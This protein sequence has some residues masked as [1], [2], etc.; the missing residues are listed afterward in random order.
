MSTSATEAFKPMRIRHVAIYV[1]QT[2]ARTF[3]GGA[4]SQDPGFNRTQPI[5]EGRGVASRPFIMGGRD[6]WA[7]FYLFVAG[8]LGGT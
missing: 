4:G 8:Q 1:L 5:M 3:T 2:T 7:V 6:L